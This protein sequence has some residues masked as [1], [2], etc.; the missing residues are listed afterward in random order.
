MSIGQEAFREYHR[1]LIMRHPTFMCPVTK[2]ILD[3]DH[4][5]VIQF[6]H[7]SKGP[8]IDVISKS[9]WDKLTEEQKENVNMRILTNWEEV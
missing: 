9:G 7:P 6:L 8:A 5:Y 1:S 2:E 3:L 4:S